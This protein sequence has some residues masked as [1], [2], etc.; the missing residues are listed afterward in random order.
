MRLRIYTDV[1]SANIVRA[2]Q[3]IISGYIIWSYI[4]VTI[5]IYKIKLKYVY[6]PFLARMMHVVPE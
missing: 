3:P 4:E 6:L 5:H 2:E 1:D